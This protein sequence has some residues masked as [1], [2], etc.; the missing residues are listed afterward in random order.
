MLYGNAS[1]ALQL[2]VL[3]VRRLAWGTMWK[4]EKTLMN[5]VSLP[6][7]PTHP[8]RIVDDVDNDFNDNINFLK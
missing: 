5:L 8:C 1:F 6:E 2:V 4:R 7:L 3:Y